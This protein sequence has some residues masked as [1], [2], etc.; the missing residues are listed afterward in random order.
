MV[1]PQAGSE[2]I[3][4]ATGES[5]YAIPVRSYIYLFGGMLVFQGLFSYLRTLCFAVVS[6]RSMADLRSDLFEKF[7]RL[8]IANYEARKVGELTSRITSDVEKLQSTVSITLAEFIRQFVILFIGLIFILW[9]APQLSL[10]MLLVFPL[11]VIAAFFFGRYIRKLSRNRQD[12]IANSN[13]IAEESLQ[14]FHTVKAY[15]NETYELIRYSSSVEKIVKISLSFAKV[16][17]LFFVFIIT[18]LFGGIFFILWRGA[19]M[20]EDGRMVAGDLFS[21]ILYTGFIG[22]AIAGIGNLYSQIVGA[23]GATER[24]FEILD[25][26]TE[27]STLDNQTGGIA[28]RYNGHIDLQN[29][30][31]SYPSRSDVIV[32][33]DINFEVPSGRRIALVGSSGAG[34]STIAQLLLRFYDPSSGRILI[35]DKDISTLNPIE[36]RSNIAIVPQDVLLFGTTIRENVLYGNHSASEEELIDACKKAQAYEFIMSFPE[37][38]ET[39]VGERGVKLSGGQRQRIAIARALLKNP[40]ILILDEATSSLDA[41]SERLVQL[42]LEEVMKGRTSIIIAHRLSTIREVDCI[43]VLDQ[44]KII[45]SGTHDDLY[46]RPESIYHSLARLQMETET[47]L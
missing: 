15:T 18:I 44:G 46:S 26:E 27:M 9:L 6:E 17:G 42:A 47:S 20:V 4:A 45:E 13:T 37:G 43:Y 16:R 40:S 10:I 8:S 36:L 24:L 2:M 25:S 30:S 14:A 31:F 38:M 5:S 41:E 22:G 19:I 28:K 3:K 33:S 32:L 34:K 7:M 23:V 35:D 39:M 29:I 21:F 12:E 1:F 11:C